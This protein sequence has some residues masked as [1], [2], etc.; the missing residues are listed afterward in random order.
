[1]SWTK[2]TKNNY[3]EG[4]PYGN[5]VDYSIFSKFISE[6]NIVS[7]REEIGCG[8]T[9]LKFFQNGGRSCGKEHIAIKDIYG[10]PFIDHYM[11]YK[12]SDGEVIFTSQPH[13]NKEKIIYNFNLCFAKDFEIRVYESSNGWYCPGEVTLFTVRLKKK[14]GNL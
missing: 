14:G 2:I 8:T 5:Y 7:Y 10:F 12:T 11:F 9:F 1:M 13:A 3:K 4:T 6:N